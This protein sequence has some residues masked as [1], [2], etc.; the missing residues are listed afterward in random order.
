MTDADHGFFPDGPFYRRVIGVALVVVLL[1]VLWRISL[2]LI[3]TFG[4]VLVA[5][6]LRSLSYPLQRLLHIPARLALII[7]TLALVF[8]VIGFFDLFGT[9]AARQFYALFHRIPDAV[10][11]GKQWLAGFVIGRQMLASAPNIGDAVAKLIEALPMAGGIL[12][13]VGEA[14]LVFAV[15]IYFA[16]DPKTYI[17]GTLRL[18]P[19][20]R[21]A[22]A[23]AILK[24]VGAALT[25]WFIGMCFDMMM[26][27]IMIFVGMWMIGMPLPFALAVLSGV[28]VFVP[29]IGPAIALIPGMLLA[30][31]VDPQMALWAGL[32][33]LV[34]LTIEGNISQPLLQRW[35]VSVPPVINLLA[36][37]AFSPLFGFWGAVL[38]TPL[39]VALTVVIRMAY[40][41]DVLKDK[42]CAENQS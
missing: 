25:N 16:A 35:A 2:V 18:I 26:L 11:A 23:R 34:A 38:A 31:S 22:R 21:R 13:G 8:A 39:S 7:V 27:A 4:G 24:T 41:E 28:A 30:F 42:R 19:Q 14:L 29:Y 17:D 32:V 9:L 6:I 33:Y 15:G 1:L 10:D 37:L 20:W 40:I 5:V 3:L 36:I 12:S